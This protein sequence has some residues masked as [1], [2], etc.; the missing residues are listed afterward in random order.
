MLRAQGVETIMKTD[1][2][3]FT[4]KSTRTVYVECYEDELAGNA[5]KSACS[6]YQ[7]KAKVADRDGTEA[8]PIPVRPEV[9]WRAQQREVTVTEGGLSRME[10]LCLSLAPMLYNDGK[11]VSLDALPKAAA[12]LACRI[13]EECEKVGSLGCDE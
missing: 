5:Y 10:M 11:G 6:D 12:E 3:H 4:G 8:P 9:T 13:V 1:N 2:R 7:F